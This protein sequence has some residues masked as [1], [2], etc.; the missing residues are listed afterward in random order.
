MTEEERF[1]ENEEAVVGRQCIEDHPA[2]D[3]KGVDFNALIEGRR[4]ADT[5]GTQNSWS[6]ASKEATH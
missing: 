2:E 5:Q 4:A 6:E 3:S 1:K